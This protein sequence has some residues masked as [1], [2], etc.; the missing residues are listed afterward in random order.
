MSTADSPL[1]VTVTLRL[2]DTETACI[3]TLRLCDTEPACI[4]AL[5][6]CDTVSVHR[7]GWSELQAGLGHQRTMADGP[8]SSCAIQLHYAV[9]T[10]SIKYDP[11]CIPLCIPLFHTKMA[12]ISNTA[13]RAFLFTLTPTL[14]SLLCIVLVVMMRS[15]EFKT[16][17]FALLLI[18]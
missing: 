17:R 11:L 7:R 8:L 10:G 18:L 12:R 2:C 3:V 14:S 1:C 15:K 9:R 6:L 5:R 16:S 4:V 13:P